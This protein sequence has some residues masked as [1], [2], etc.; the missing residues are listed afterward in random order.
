MMKLKVMVMLLAVSSTAQAV[1]LEEVSAVTQCTALAVEVGYG[2]K[3]HQ[4]VEK[5]IARSLSLYKQ[6]MAESNMSIDSPE[7]LVSGFTQYYQGLGIS[8]AYSFIEDALHAK[9]VPLHGTEWATEAGSQFKQ[10]N[11]AVIIGK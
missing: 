1:Q 5:G 10:R 11:C 3:A 8:H 2:S 9:G 4:Y 7:A 6:T